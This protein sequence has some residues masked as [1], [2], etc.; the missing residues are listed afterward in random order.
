M[1]SDVHQVSRLRYFVPEVTHQISIDGVVV[2]FWPHLFVRHSGSGVLLDA[3]RSEDKHN[4]RLLGN[5]DFEIYQKNIK[6][7]LTKHIVLT[8]LV[9]DE[10]EKRYLKKGADE[11][12]EAP[13]T[14]SGTDTTER[15]ICTTRNIYNTDMYRINKHREDGAHTDEPPH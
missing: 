4:G 15:L 12:K 14:S 9:S 10:L 5:I 1:V 7:L 6:W 2:S 13:R 8:T 3:P 11:R